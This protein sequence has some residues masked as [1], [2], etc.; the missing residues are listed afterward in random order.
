MGVCTHQMRAIELE[1]T[2]EE[3]QENPQV[4]EA[5]LGGD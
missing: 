4:Q 3:V 2:A 5:Y 1:G